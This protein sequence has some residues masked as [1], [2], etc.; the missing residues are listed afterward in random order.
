MV[1]EPLS[2]NEIQRR[3]YVLLVDPSGT[4]AVAYN[5]QHRVTVER[6]SPALLAWALQHHVHA[7]DW[8]DALDVH[9]QRERAAWM[10]TGSLAGWRLYWV[11][12]GYTTD[13]TLRAMPLK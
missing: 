4:Q 13:A 2:V 9:W 1:E 6:V 11:R 3:P 12:N 10:P 5:P 7:S 8:D